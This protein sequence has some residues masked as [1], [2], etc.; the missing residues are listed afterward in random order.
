M[1]DRKK[2]NEE[3]KNWFLSELADNDNRDKTRIYNSLFHRAAGYE[4]ILGKDI[5]GFNYEDCEGLILHLKTKSI[6]SMKTYKSY[7]SHYINWAIKNNLVISGQNHWHKIPEYDEFIRDMF[8]RRHIKCLDTLI[9]I[10]EKHIY[11]KYEKLA[12]Y[13]LYSGVTKDEIISAAEKDIDME[14]ET[15]WVGAR[16]Q[17]LPVVGVAIDTLGKP[18]AEYLHY[19]KLRVVDQHSEKLIKPYIYKRRRDSVS[20]LFINRTLEKLNK[21]RLAETK[22]RTYFT[23]TTILKSGFFYEMHKLELEKGKLEKGD[24]ISMAKRF[25]LPV[26]NTQGAYMNLT[27]REYKLYKQVFWDN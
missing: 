17:T 23:P 1:S 7:L 8:E 27:E 21:R 25:K 11:R 18:E 4:E 20:G 13:L 22:A 2:Y 10:V 16:S 12:V 26:L 15:I 5:T 3:V 19:E 9:N 6:K 24:F 14:A